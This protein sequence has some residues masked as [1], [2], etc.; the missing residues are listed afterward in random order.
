[1]RTTRKKE[2]RE[3]QER[4]FKSGEGVWMFR[5]K[6]LTIK[7]RSYEP[8]KRGVPSGLNGTNGSEK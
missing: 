7:K 8:R 1:M 2:E 3:R 4:K 6:R 5:F